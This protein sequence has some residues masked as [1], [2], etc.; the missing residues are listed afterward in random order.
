MKV[1]HGSDVR[2]DTLYQTEVYVRLANTDSGLYAKS[3]Q[4]IYE[5][6]KQELRTPE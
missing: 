4:E 6:V 3:R 2:I 5:M 1:Y